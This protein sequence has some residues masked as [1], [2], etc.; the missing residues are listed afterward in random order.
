MWLAGLGDGIGMSLTSRPTFRISLSDTARQFV[1]DNVDYEDDR[2]IIS[3]ILKQ[4]GDLYK[5]FRSQPLF[6]KEICGR[7]IVLGEIESSEQFAAPLVMCSRGVLLQ[8]ETFSDDHDAWRVGIL[9][10]RSGVMRVPQSEHF[11][12][13]ALAIEEINTNGGVLG[14]PIE[15]IA[16]DP[17]SDPATYRELAERLLIDDGVRTI[18]GCSTSAERKAV[19]P[20]IER[21]N[22]L[23]W[24][25]SLYEGFEYSPN[26][27]YTGAV[28]NQNSIQLAQFLTGTYGSRIFLIGSDYIYP[29][30]SNRVMKEL[31]DAAQG[32][33]VGEEYF[34]LIF[35]ES[36]FDQTFERLRRIRPDA[37][38]STLVGESGIAFYR[39]YAD[40]DL[41]ASGVPIASLTM[42]EGEI[43]EIG[44]ALAAG[45]VTA[46]PYFSTVETL[47]NRQFTE[48]FRKKFGANCPVSMYAESAYCQVH[49]F[50]QALAACGTT[51]PQILAREA[52]GGQFHGPQGAVTIDPDNNHAYV[53]PRIGIVTAEGTFRIV[54]EEPEPI[55]PDPYLV[56]YD[57]DLLRH[58]E[59]SRHQD[60]YQGEPS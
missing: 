6:L 19:L 33:I 18:F 37:I 2:K 16:Y 22:G 12:G 29:R 40:T 60:V 26:I 31:I 34:P 1:F 9:F 49:L 57:Y 53:T 5:F 10:S 44:G 7:I 23:L 48:R 32:A 41:F 24:Y 42:A 4:S 13:T 28:P 17:G 38:F 35:P 58:G 55:K 3:I 47:A 36:S 50:A 27:I 56:S 43:A 20:S 46:A 11:F 59:R 21:W 14:R 45:H 8:S 30:E 25:P 51:T 54:H 39:Q 52:L 15:P